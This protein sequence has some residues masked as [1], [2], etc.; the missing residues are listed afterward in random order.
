[1]A[2]YGYSLD[3][4]EEL[5]KELEEVESRITQ[6]G[7]VKK[8]DDDDGDDITVDPLFGDEET[9][10]KSRRDEKDELADDDPEDDL[11]KMKKYQNSPK[12]A[13]KK[14][15]EWKELKELK[16]PVHKKEAT[17]TKTTKEPSKEPSREPAKKIKV[18]RAVEKPVILRTEKKEERKQKTKQSIEPP[19]VEPQPIVQAV[20]DEGTDWV[21]VG[22]WIAVLLLAGYFAW[23]FFQPVSASSD[24]T[25]CAVTSAG[26]FSALVLEEQKVANIRAFI[27]DGLATVNGNEAKTFFKKASCSGDV[28]FCDAKPFVIITPKTLSLLGVSAPAPC[29]KAG[30]LIAC[31]NNVIIEEGAATVNGKAP[32]SITTVSSGVGTLKE[33]SPDG[34]VSATI[35]EGKE[36]LQAVTYPRELTGSTIIKLYTRDGADTA[37]FLIQ[38]E[39]GSPR[40]VGYRA[41]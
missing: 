19:I 21:T 17:K 2:K 6:Y 16:A 23:S 39:T 22:V 35:Y 9:P 32:Y 10:T 18:E 1:M 40:V 26:N 33:Y 8:S 7:K 12:K 14:E 36:G 3:V 38:Y 25:Q 5:E 4:G 28:S 20:P 41:E 29:R 31:D 24:A 30:T 15:E 27:R 11:P 37:G 13:P 34:T